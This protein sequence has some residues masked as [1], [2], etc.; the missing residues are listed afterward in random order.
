MGKKTGKRYSEEQIIRILNELKSGKT[1]EVCRTYSV[2][3]STLCLAPSSC[4]SGS[5][6][7]LIIPQLPVLHRCAVAQ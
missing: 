5:E 1:A 2:A 3:Q 4:T 6:S 7:H